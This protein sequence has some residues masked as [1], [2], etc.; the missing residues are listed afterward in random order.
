MRISARS[1]AKSDEAEK[2]NSEKSRRQRFGNGYVVS[3]VIQQE[4]SIIVR[5]PT[6]GDCKFIDIYEIGSTSV[7]LLADNADSILPTTVPFSHP[8]IRM[9]RE[10]VFVKA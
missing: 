5:Q 6:G 8:S 1:T 3:E 10:L 4:I 9:L 7:K 2:G